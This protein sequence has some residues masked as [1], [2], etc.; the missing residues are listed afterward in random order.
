MENIIE[1]DLLKW[2]FKGLNKSSSGEKWTALQF[3]IHKAKDRLR[4]D[5]MF[6]ERQMD[7]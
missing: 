5:N 4:Y 1:T 2:Y 6:L 3:S 7:F